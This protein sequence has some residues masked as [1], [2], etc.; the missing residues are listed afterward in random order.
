V[1]PPAKIPIRILQEVILE[2]FD[3]LEGDLL[4]FSHDSLGIKR[5]FENNKCFAVI[6]CN[7]KMIQYNITRD[8]KFF[9]RG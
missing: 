1:K 4:N 6:V 2:S 3:L 5:N 7:H 9:Q 8:R